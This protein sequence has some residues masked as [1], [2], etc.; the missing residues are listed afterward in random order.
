MVVSALMLVLLPALSQ[1][2]WSAPSISVQ[3]GALV[4]LARGAS[5]PF[6]QNSPSPEHAQLLSPQK[7][8][9]V[10]RVVDS[11]PSIEQQYPGDAAV[12][13]KA[14]ARFVHEGMVVFTVISLHEPAPPTLR[15]RRLKQ[16]QGSFGGH[17]RGFIE[18]FRQH[19]QGRSPM[20]VCTSLRTKRLA[21]RLVG[22]N[23]SA[24]FVANWLQWPGS[25]GKRRVATFDSGLN[26]DL[27]PS[28]NLKYLWAYFIV[29]SDVSAFFLDAD[30]RLLRPPH[31]FIALQ[32]RRG[33]FYTTPPRHMPDMLAQLDMSAGMTELQANRFHALDERPLRPYAAAVPAAVDCVAKKN[34]Y[35]HCATQGRYLCINTG[36]M[37]FFP[38]SGSERILAAM[39]HLLRSHWDTWWEQTMCNHVVARLLES[40][41]LK[42]DWLEPS[43]F[44]YLHAVVRYPDLVIAHGSL[45]QFR[46]LE[47]RSHTRI[48]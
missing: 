38:G 44:Q 3:E 1:A 6:F 20:I 30:T 27:D 14:I 15:G 28:V 37:V 35:H 26:R 17:V 29:R 34:Y 11:P 45:G 16:S 18:S 13:R 33:I 31:P 25:V 2:H 19:G 43:M 46:K 47:N 48:V 10:A 5:G 36:M 21:E 12:A 32:Q 22:G 24:Y 41:G 39:L 9:S 42:F 40:G 23:N 8:D 4:T 7:C